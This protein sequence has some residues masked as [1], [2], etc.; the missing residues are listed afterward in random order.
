[1]LNATGFLTYNNQRK[2]YQLSNKDKL[3]E[4]KLP[5][6]MLLLILKVVELRQTVPLKSG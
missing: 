3:T 5:V 6:R 1:M 4:Y 2:E